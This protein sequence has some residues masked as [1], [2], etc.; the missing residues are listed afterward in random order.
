[1]PLWLQNLLVLLAVLACVAFIARG[2]MLALRGSKS[3]LGGCGTC[4]GCATPP[5]TQA[6][7]K[8]DAERIAI[9]PADMLVKRRTPHKTK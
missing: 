9:I 3:R 1:M 6:K 7:P 5:A 4:S 2:A 8:S